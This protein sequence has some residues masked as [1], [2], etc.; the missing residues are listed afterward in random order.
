MH[1]NFFVGSLIG[2]VALG[3]A[4][5]PAVAFDTRQVPTSRGNVPLYVP[6]TIGPGTS[7]PL[8]VSLH[9]YTGNGTEHE[10]YFNLRSQVDGQQFMLCVPEG[11]QNFSG[12]RFWNATDVCCG[13]GGAFSVKMADISS[14]ILDEKLDNIEATG[15]NTVIAADT[16][17]IYQMQGGLRR[18][19][20]DVQVV[21]IAEILAK[22]ISGPAQTGTRA[23]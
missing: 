14:A 7:L 2:G 10:N 18:R 3:P 21:H 4:T 16:G 22:S 5:L 15:V 9:G 12:D 6:S 17:C 19:G 1:L 23:R 20:S 8:V 13:F 11:T